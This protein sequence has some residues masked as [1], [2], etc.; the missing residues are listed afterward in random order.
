MVLLFFVA[1]QSIELVQRNKD[2][3]LPLSYSLWMDV[4]SEKF[5]G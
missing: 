4:T 5:Q 3:K 2:P 1:T